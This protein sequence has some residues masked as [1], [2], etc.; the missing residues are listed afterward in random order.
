[1]QNL[2]SESTDDEIDLGEVVHLEL[3]AQGGPL[4]DNVS[5]NGPPVALRVEQVQVLALVLQELAT[6]ATKYGA[7]KEGN[8]RLDVAWI[9]EPDA[10]GDP[11]LRLTWRESGVAMPA[12]TSRQGYGRRLIERSLAFTL[13]ATTEL[14]FGPDGVVCR[15]EV[16]LPEENSAANG[17]PG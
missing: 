14:S 11:L 16:P 8:G 7:L 5:V 17:E 12:D 9:V 13:R 6:N 10:Q 3:G 15:I 2:I 1:V 4:D